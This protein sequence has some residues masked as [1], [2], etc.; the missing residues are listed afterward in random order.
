[1]EV[2]YLALFLFAYTFFKRNLSLVQ[3]LYILTFV[4]ALLARR[5][6]YIFYGLVPTNCLPSLYPPISD[7]HSSIDFC[8]FAVQRASF[9]PFPFSVH[10]ESRYRPRLRF[11]LRHTYTSAYIAIDAF[12]VS[13]FVFLSAFKFRF[14]S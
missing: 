7:G 1:M 14:D 6:A 9:F 8:F 2:K 13:C 11:T 3:P 12:P 10:T 5:T 4:Q